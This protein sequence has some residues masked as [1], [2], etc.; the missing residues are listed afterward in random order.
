MGK[1]V[2]YLREVKCKMQVEH[3]QW[4]MSLPHEGKE[5]VQLLQPQGFAQ[6]EVKMGM[7]DQ[8]MPA[9]TVLDFLPGADLQRYL[10]SLLLRFLGE[11]DQEQLGI[12]KKRKK[13]VCM[14]VCVNILYMRTKVN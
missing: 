6:L 10:A 13:K 1:T 9:Q 5:Q 11:P 7:V 3:Q 8:E 2:I 4:N 14:Y 12:F